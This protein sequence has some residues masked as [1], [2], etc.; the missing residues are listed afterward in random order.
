MKEAQIELWDAIDGWKVITTN[1]SVNKKGL[2]VM[3]RGCALEAA[4]RFPQ[5]PKALAMLL[6]K[7]GNRVYVWEYHKKENTQFKCNNI[8]TFPVKHNWYEKADLELIKKSAMELVE[9]A[10]RWKM[11]KVYLP[12]PGCGYGYL[13]WEEVKKEIESILDDRF[14]VIT[15]PI[16]TIIMQYKENKQRDS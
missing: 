14:I 8:I 16:K 5:F 15:K 12:R 3:G 13:K 9:V 7:T 1:G 11:E 2:A 4:K 6:T 10:N